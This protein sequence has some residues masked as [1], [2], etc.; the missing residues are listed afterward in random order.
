M[1]F[2]KRDTFAYY[3]TSL[4]CD[5]PICMMYD[6][7]SQVVGFEVRSGYD[8][9]VRVEHIEGR[10]S[11]RGGDGRYSLRYSSDAT[12]RHATRR[13][14]WPW[15]TSPATTRYNLALFPDWGSV[16]AMTKFSYV[17][18]SSRKL[19]CSA[20]HLAQPL[21]LSKNGQRHPEKKIQKLSEAA[22]R[23]PLVV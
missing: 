9:S 11:H 10:R 1:S 13:S 17:G 4:L 22:A 5:S 14:R 8:G 20:V 21:Q 12:R 3:L 2:N 18:R 7:N 19:E 15:S 6:C 23:Q 16:R